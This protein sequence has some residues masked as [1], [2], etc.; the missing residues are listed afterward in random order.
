MN[1]HDVEICD[2]QYP[3][4]QR[5]KALLVKAGRTFA[6]QGPVALFQ[7]ILQYTERAYTFRRIRKSFKFTPRPTQA[8]INVAGYLNAETGLGESARTLIRSIKT[9]PIKHALINYSLKRLKERDLC[10]EMEFTPCNPGNIN[11]IVINPDGL[12]LAFLHLGD[13][14]FSGRYNIGYWAWELP[15]I[16][17]EWK[18]YEESFDE[19]WVPSEFVR[20]ALH[21]TI[22]KPVHV[23]PHSIEVKSFNH[24]GRGHFDCAREAFVF[25]FIFDYHSLFERKNP[26]AVVQSFKK[27][28]QGDENA[29]LIVKCS[30]PAGFLE[31]HH[32]LLKE[33][34]A[35]RRIK[36]ISRRLT[37]DEISSLL[38]ISDAYV[39]LHRS[40]GFGL[41]M[42][43]AMFLEKPVICTAYSGNLDFTRE[44]NAFLVGWR[45]TRLE[46]NIGPYK[47]GD[48][49]V[50]ADIDEAAQCMRQA[51]HQEA[52]RKDKALQGRQFVQ[53]YLNPESVG[54][55]ILQRFEQ[56]NARG[57]E[58]PL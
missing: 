58:P 47:E 34:G 10:Y 15:D 56:I 13:D 19:F 55:K 3:F 54:R 16:P 35:D 41:T 4:P 23:I 26:G 42:A 37:R 14:F 40:E 32:L 24:Y 1:K 25:S 2:D 7:N 50:D 57:E 49:W 9:T 39:S 18:K 36:I 48:E 6:G 28:F 46:K 21:K 52:L 29:Q 5:I 22:D 33:I 43:E 27:A 53:S 17:P 31:Q 38:D 12:D 44:D 45:K 51:Y 11:V 8:G 30:D 20:Q